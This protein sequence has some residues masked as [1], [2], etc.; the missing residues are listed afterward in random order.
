MARGGWSQEAIRRLVG[1][2]SGLLISA[3]F[4][5]MLP[6]SLG[7]GAHFNAL[8]ALIGFAFLYILEDFFLQDNVHS[9]Q[10]ASV[11]HESEAQN[12]IE[13]EEGMGITVGSAAAIGMLVHTFFDGVAIASGFHSNWEVG[14]LVVAAIIS[15]KLPAGFIVASA[16]EASSFERHKILKVLV[17]LGLSTV[18][19]AVLAGS[20]FLKAPAAR[21][22]AK[23]RFVSGAL[24]FSAGM[25]IYLAASDLIPQIRRK[26]GRRV[27]PYVLG[28]IVIFSLLHFLISG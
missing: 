26:C 27:A 7:E 17:G 10:A 6:E 15:H 21:L 3:A 16:M 8:L 28:G 19:G 5:D 14:F 11:N 25:F 9:H 4:L 22:H 20:F 12:R 13:R 1:I 24:A 23:A 18:V 2:S